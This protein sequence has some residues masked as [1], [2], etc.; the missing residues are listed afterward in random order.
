MPCALPPPPPSPSRLPSC[1]LPPFCLRRLPSCPLP[2]ALPPPPPLAPSVSAASPRILYHACCLCRLPS[3]P[4]PHAS[5]PLPPLTLSPLLLI[6]FCS[7]IAAQVKNGFCF[8]LC[9]E[10]EGIWVRPGGFLTRWGR[11][12]GCF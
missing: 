11:G 6:F 12:Y 7:L 3:R 2:C 1:P 4:P 10:G 9:K 5:L 8:D